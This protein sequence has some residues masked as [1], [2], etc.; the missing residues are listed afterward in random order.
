MLKGGLA[1][2]RLAAVCLSVNVA[3]RRRAPLAKPSNTLPRSLHIIQKMQGRAG[4]GRAG[5]GRAGRGR[6]GRGGAGQ[7]GAGRGR[8][9]QGRALSRMN[10]QCSCGA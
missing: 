10:A 2:Y 6:A 5:Q 4:Q 8:A 9:G 1:R 7:G 3:L